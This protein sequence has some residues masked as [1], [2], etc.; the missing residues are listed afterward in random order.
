MGV[1]LFYGLVNLT[2]SKVTGVPVY[3][4]LSWDSILSWSIALAIF[5]LALGVY[6]ALYYGTQLKF[7]Y[8]RMG[9][10]LVI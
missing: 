10:T 4:P 7:R 1:L 2:V 8:L 9:E 5:P 3:P 6:A